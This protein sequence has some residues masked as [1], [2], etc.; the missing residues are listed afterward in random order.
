M[1][2][3]IKRTSLAAL[4]YG[5]GM[6]ASAAQSEGPPPLIDLAGRQCATTPDFTHAL[7][8]ANDPNKEKE[9]KTDIGASMPCLQGANGAS[10]YVVYAL[11]P[12]DTHYTVN[13]ASNLSGHTLFAPRVTLYGADGT[14]RREFAGTAIVFRGNTLCVLFR[15]HEDERYLVVSSDPTVVGQRSSRI[16]DSTMMAGA[17]AGPV[18]FQ[19]HTG[20]EA[21]SDF[22]YAHNGSITITLAPLPAK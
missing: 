17:M 15:S 7:S 4:L 6:S 20:S 3:A 8:L 19:I 18:I 13:V 12:A 10:V 16:T 1:K 2:G 21:K 5:V 11:P 14:L 9:T 22:T